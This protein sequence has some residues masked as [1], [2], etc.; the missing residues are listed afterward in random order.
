MYFQ[1]LRSRLLGGRGY[2]YARWLFRIFDLTLGALGPG[3]LRGAMRG[4]SSRRLHAFRFK[5]VGIY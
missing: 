2:V 4:T 1:V 3:S 5:V